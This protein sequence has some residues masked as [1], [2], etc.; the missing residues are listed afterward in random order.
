MIP[1][2]AVE[3]YEYEKEKAMEELPGKKTGPRKPA[4]WMCSKT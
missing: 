2:T 1:V 4:S 3:P